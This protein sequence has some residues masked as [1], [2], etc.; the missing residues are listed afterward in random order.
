MIA[1]IVFYA[2]ANFDHAGGAGN[3]GLSSEMQWGQREGR[4]TGT[5]Y[6]RCARASWQQVFEMQVLWC[7]CS[8][9]VKENTSKIP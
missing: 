3:R 1:M 4:C 9:L 5:D 6:M 2:P 8:K 7:Q